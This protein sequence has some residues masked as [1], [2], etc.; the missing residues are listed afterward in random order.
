MRP[1]AGREPHEEGVRGR[2]DRLA[3]RRDA[4]DDLQLGKIGRDRAGARLAAVARAASHRARRNGRMRPGRLGNAEIG[5]S[6]AGKTHIPGLFPAPGSGVGQGRLDDPIPAHAAAPDGRPARGAGDPGARRRRGRGAALSSA[7]A[8]P[9]R[10]P[11][12]GSGQRRRSHLG[13]VRPLAGRL[14][15]PADDVRVSGPLFGDDSVLAGRSLGQQGSGAAGVRRHGRDVRDSR[16]LL[17]GQW[18]RLRQ[19]VAD[20]RHAEPLPV[21][22]Q[23]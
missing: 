15:Q 8:R 12:A 16:P 9:G 13:R 1:R 22:G 4:G 21:Q 23:G 11:R 14:D 19:Q 10:F 18:P 20:R 7:T 17:A 5:L 6:A 2:S 3:L